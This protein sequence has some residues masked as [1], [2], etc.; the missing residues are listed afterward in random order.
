MFSPVGGLQEPYIPLQDV[1]WWGER[2][3]FVSAHPSYHSHPAWSKDTCGRRFYFSHQY[4]RIVGAVEAW[5]TTL[6]EGQADEVVVV[7][8]WYAHI[9]YI[10]YSDHRDHS[11]LADMLWKAEGS[12]FG[13]GAKFDTV[14]FD[15]WGPPDQ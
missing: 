14:T 1:S 13:L 2:E 10:R 15:I 6:A 11:S 4:V 12:K 3:E 5:A 9:G 7:H 8:L